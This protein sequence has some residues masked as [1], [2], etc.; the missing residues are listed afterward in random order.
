MKRFL[1]GLGLLALA[2][3][4]LAAPEFNVDVEAAGDNRT[5]IW[6][7]YLADGNVTALDF[8]VKLDAPDSVRVDTRECLVSLPK[9]HAGLCRADGNKLRGVIYSRT[10]TLLRDTNIGSV[11]I[12]PDSLLKAA[13]SSDLEI[14]DVQVNAVTPQGATVQADVRVSGQRA[15]SGKAG[16]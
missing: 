5:R 8:T 6:L 11:T 16:D 7:S 10:N 9:S 3:P 4:A 15:Q 2:V 14:N 13:G 12:D 1:T